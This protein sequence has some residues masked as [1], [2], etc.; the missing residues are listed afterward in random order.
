MIA[1]SEDSEKELAVP[2][3]IRMTSKQIGS[4]YSYVVIN[5]QR[6]YSL[7]SSKIVDVKERFEYFPLD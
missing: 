3:L 1:D 6:L 2:G 7:L 4:E 5:Q